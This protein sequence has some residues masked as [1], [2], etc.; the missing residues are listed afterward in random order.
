M[1]GEQGRSNQ[2]AATAVV[3]S[4]TA[5]VGDLETVFREH[6]D[7][8][9]RA[10]YRVTG[11]GADAEDVMQTVFLRLAR[12]P[13]GAESVDNVGSYL[14]RAA[15]N[16]A[17]DLMR[18]R[19]N[20]HNMPLEEVAPELV[21]D[22]S[23]A[24]DRELTSAEILTWVRNTVAR[25]SP[26]AAEVFALRFYEGLDNGEIARILGASQSTVAVTLHRT[27]ERL[28]QE[29]RAFTGDK[30]QPNARKGGSHA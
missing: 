26:R 20:A 18:S 22:P 8:V 24:P 29:F 9:F 2:V 19:Q 3:P 15:V 16:A 17:L 4:S 5:S 21:A 23:L 12:R 10:A 13:A 30:D 27:R 14:H 28:L 11:N 25:L 1:D 6:H 7:H